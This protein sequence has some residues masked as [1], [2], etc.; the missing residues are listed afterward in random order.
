MDPISLMIAGL[1]DGMSSAAGAIGSAATGL[2]DAAAS[3]AQ[4]LVNG[5]KSAIGLGGSAN[6]A[7]AGAAP[8]ASATAPSTAAASAP[9]SWLEQATD[10]FKSAKA[11]PLGQIIGAMKPAQSPQPVFQGGF[12][13]PHLPQTPAIHAINP[14]ENYAA[15]QAA[16]AKHTPTLGELLAQSPIGRLSS[17]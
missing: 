2:G 9:K 16:N 14:V 1:T 4:S 5:A 7:A 3:G 13:G 6:P 11:S 17:R 8:V 10:A 12:Q 15:L